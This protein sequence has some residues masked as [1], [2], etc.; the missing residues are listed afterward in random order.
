M[1]FLENS[2]FPELTVLLGNDNISL[3]ILEFQ[4]YLINSLFV[5][6]SVK[7][8]FFLTINLAIILSVLWHQVRNLVC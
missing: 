5:K 7:G 1:I 4:I 2:L 3:G 8:T 6:L